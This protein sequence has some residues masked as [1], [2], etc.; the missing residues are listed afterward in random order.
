[1]ASNTSKVYCCVRFSENDGTVRKTVIPRNWVE[2][3]FMYWSDSFNATKQWKMCCSPEKTWPRYKVLKILVE[4]GMTLN[5]L[6]FFNNFNIS[7][8]NK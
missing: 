1:M 7:L 5:I 6:F 2:G 3:G 8:W 4:G